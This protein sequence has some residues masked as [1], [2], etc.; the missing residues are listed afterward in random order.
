MANGYAPTRDQMRVIAEAARDLHRVVRRWVAH[1]DLPGFP[2][3]RWNRMAIRAL[4]DLERALNPERLPWGNPRRGH[5]RTRCW[6]LEVDGGLTWLRNLLDRIL[7]R[8]RL[9]ALAIQ[10]D[11]RPCPDDPDALPQVISVER[12]ELT[13]LREAIRMLPRLDTLPM[14]ERLPEAQDRSEL[15]PRGAEEKGIDPKTPVIFVSRRVGPIVLGKRKKI[16]TRPQYDV[17]K[18]IL[19]SRDQCLSKKG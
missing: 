13:A 11:L 2:A 7:E 1:A 17:V 14:R 12:Q 9:Q 15:P 4:F 16:L 8:N 5:P 10:A 6:A 18:A 3:E 19:D